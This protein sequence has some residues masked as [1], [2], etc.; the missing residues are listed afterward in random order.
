ML[1]RQDGKKLSYTLMPRLQ[2][3]LASESVTLSQSVLLCHSRD[4]MLVAVV[5]P[6]VAVAMVCGDDT[7]SKVD[8][9]GA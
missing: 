1:S 2:S 3:R 7:F 4:F 6:V 8:I 9:C 5:E